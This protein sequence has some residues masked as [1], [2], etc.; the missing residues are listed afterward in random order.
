MMIENTERSETIE[1]S[2]DRV[3][4]L[5][6]AGAFSVLALWPM[7]HGGAI[8]LWAILL[9]AVFLVLALAVPRALSRLN[10]LWMRLGLLMGRVVSPVAIGIVYYLTVVPTGL[11]MRALGKHP[12]RL[13]FDKELPS[14]WIKREPP[15][16]DP[17]S[18]SD[19]F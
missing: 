2:S 1:G 9:A 16:P 12:M 13:G 4:G 17:K 18:M 10:R 7:V 11:I 14:Y 15:G 3:F 19:Q 6:F 8:R 5:V